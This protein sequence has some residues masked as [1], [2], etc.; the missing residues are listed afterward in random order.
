MNPS[1]IICGLWP[2]RKNLKATS[3]LRL[4]FVE[5]E[6]FYGKFPS[7]LQFEIN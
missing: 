2:N 4:T 5:V 1:L 7:I 6:S 3:I